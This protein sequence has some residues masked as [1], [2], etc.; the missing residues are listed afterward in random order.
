MYYKGFN[1]I[2]ELTIG[3]VHSLEKIDD[4]TAK[5]LTKIKFLAGKAHYTREE[6]N[7]ERM[8]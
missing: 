6:L 4:E 8:D 2:Y 1:N 3:Y 5:K 7:F